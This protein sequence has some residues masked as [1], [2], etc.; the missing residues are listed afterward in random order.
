MTKA[1]KRLRR[2][3]S[4]PADFTW[5]ELVALLADLGFVEVSATGGSYR[6]FVA[7]SGR[8]IFIHR[9]HPNA[10]LKRYAIREVIAVLEELG[11]LRG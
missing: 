2:L 5:D 3:L 6:T 1:E 9:P 4:V 11:I 7:R 10:V 8:K